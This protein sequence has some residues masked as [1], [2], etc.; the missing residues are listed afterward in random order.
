[1]TTMKIFQF[2]TWIIISIQ[3]SPAVNVMTMF[4][5]IFHWITNLNYSSHAN[6]I[7]TR[8]S[9]TRT[10][11]TAPTPAKFCNFRATKLLKYSQRTST[12]KNRKIWHQIWSTGAWIPDR[13]V[14]IDSELTVASTSTQ[15]EEDVS[16]NGILEYEATVKDVK[17]GRDHFTEVLITPKHHLTR[18]R[19]S[20]VTLLCHALK[21]S[22][23]RHIF[24][25]WFP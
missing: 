20:R 13:D 7:E 8:D 19:R 12:N 15:S 11:W 10:D 2:F 6:T 22:H 25:C 18:V 21:F 5:M 16:H 9:R 17:I 14:H 23:I 3:P 24:K 4:L 1:M